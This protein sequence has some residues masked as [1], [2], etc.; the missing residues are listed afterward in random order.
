MTNLRIATWNIAGGHTINSN[1]TFDYQGE[2]LAYFISELKKI[3]ADVICLQ[4]S[5]INSS[6][7]I[8]KE[9]AQKLHFSYVREDAFSPSHIDEDYQLSLAIISKFPFDDSSSEIFPYP[10]FKLLWRDG[11]E[12]QRHNKGVQ[13]IKIGNLTIANAHLLPIRLWNYRYE[14]DEGLQFASKIDEVLRTHLKEPIIFCAD[15][16]FNNPLA[17]YTSLREKLALQDALVNQP[18]TRPTDDTEKQNPD[19]ILYSKGISFVRSEVVKTN[20]D[21]YLCFADFSLDDSLI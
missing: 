3:E 7:S 1:A 15:F 14:V 10:Q 13:I 2:D 5:H 21:H 18:I 4:E 9:I 20:T 17:I 16:N 8:A 6:R 19:H 11:T 12:A